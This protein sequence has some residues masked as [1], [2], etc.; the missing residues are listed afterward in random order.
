MWAYAE[1]AYDLS[2]GLLQGNTEIVKIEL[3]TSNYFI[4]MIH[5]TIKNGERDL[6]RPWKGTLS[7]M[8][9]VYAL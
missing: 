7:I 6:K 8:F 1:L 4:V 9:T 2:E 5:I 3:I